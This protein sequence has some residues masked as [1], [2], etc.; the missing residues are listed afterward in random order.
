MR[1][2]LSE[3]ELQAQTNPSHPPQDNPI[4]PISS[5]KLL[6]LLLGPVLTAILYF[7]PPP[8]DMPVAAWHLVAVTMWMVVWWLSEAVPLAVT[9]L[10]PIVVMPVL[11]IA[12][13]G[14]V[15]ERYGN[16]LIFLFL[17]GFILAGGM[18]RWGLHRRIAL[19]I[20]RMIGTTPARIVMGFMLATAFLSMWISNTA[21]AVM[22]YAVGVSVI[23]FIDERTDDKKLV[24][25][26]GVGLML[27]IAYAA[28]IGGVG[29]LIGTPP[30]ALLAGLMADTYGIE[31][32]FL[33]WMMIGVPVV[34][35]MLPL[36]YLLL[37]RVV[38]PTPE[39][40]LDEVRSVIDDEYR[41]LGKMDRGE[42]I[43]AV[44]FGAAAFL[45]V[46]R[47]FLG[48]PIT[49]SGIAMAAALL[50]FAIPVG[51]REGFV[52]DWSIARS[53][54]W[55]VLMLF[56]GGL[57]LAGAF[58]STGLAEWIGSQVAS[59]ESLNLWL[60]ILV[61]TT[62]IVFLTEITS[63]T[64]STATFLPILGAVAAGLGVATEYLTV[65]VALGASM[66][67]MMPVATPPNAIVFSY[68]RMTLGDM[69][70]AG[71]ALN[72]LSIAV[73][74]LAMRLLAGPVFGI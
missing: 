44:V 35:V 74:F 73:V 46:T 40:K 30:N 7:L 23:E 63:N 16:H 15:T 17:G 33:Q 67:F 56:G 1:K 47:G 59:L 32:D 69:V 11:G 21:T 19:F 62:A 22:M 70:K 12:P 29:T 53:L 27:A 43:V 41:K 38:F 6:A 64:A 31:I 60:L 66:A 65:P 3:K 10:L 37:T 71:F 5:G 4:E 18:Q 51:R 58:N 2:D 20:V 8:A 26:F 72:F 13:I 14:D 36:T 57:A 55:G 9:A 54:P 50:L 28:S 52:L 25:N 42:T 34:I 61:V 48:L 49:D 45:W 68:E 24:H 39:L